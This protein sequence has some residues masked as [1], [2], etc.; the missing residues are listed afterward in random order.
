MRG[1]FSA[2]TVRRLSFGKNYKC[3][4]GAKRGD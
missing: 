4:A 3:N 1:D 2:V